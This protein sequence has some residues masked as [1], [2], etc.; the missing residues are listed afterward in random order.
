[1]NVHFAR[2]YL[3]LSGPLLVLPFWRNDYYWHHVISTTTEVSMMM[4]MT[5]M[6]MVTQLL[7]MLY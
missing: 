1:M 6:V 7:N 4:M 3:S 2:M 5:M